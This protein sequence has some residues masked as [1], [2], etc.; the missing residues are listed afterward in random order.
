MITPVLIESI[1]WGTYLF[2]AVLNAIFFPILYFFYPET[3][4]HNQ[5]PLRQGVPMLT[6]TYSA[7]RTLEEIDL[8]F[9]KGYLEKMSYVK[10]AKEL[11]R[12]TEQEIDARAREYGFV[13]SDDEAGM[14]KDARFGEK[15]SDLATHANGQ[16]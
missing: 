10:A 11:P 9:A 16:V 13:S 1:G 2:F 12:M 15:E 14:V 7:G 8:I 3:Y 4:V 6:P 5:H